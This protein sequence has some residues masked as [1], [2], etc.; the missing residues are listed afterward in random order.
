LTPSHR[1]LLQLCTWPEVEAYLT[2]SRGV[3]VP[4][5]S[6]EQHGPTGLIGTDA[7][8]AEVIAHGAGVAAGA[9]VGPTIALGPAQFNLGFAGTV[10]VRPT[11]LIALI[12]DYVLSLARHGFERFYFLNGH[13]GNVAPARA[14]FQ[15]IYTPLSLA[16]AADPRTIRCRLRSWWEHPGV[17]RLRR[18]LYGDWEGVHATP[19]EVAIVQHA[20]RD[21]VRTTPMTDPVA[22]PAAYARDHPSDDHFDAL[23]HRARFPDGRVGSDP[24]LATPEAGRRLVEAA[25]ADVSADYGAFLAEP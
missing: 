12:Q 13:G 20:V 4:I 11:T 17:D 19:S 7:L 23:H 3:I 25:I 14:A 1:T 21:A 18:E 22:L 9:L 2:R 8:C 16:G 10:S 5:G 24:S 6:T 15:E